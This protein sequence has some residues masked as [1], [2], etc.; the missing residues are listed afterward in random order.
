MP[1]L[2]KPFELEHL[3]LTLAHLSCVT[4][5]HTDEPTT[6]KMREM[7]ELHLI[8]QQVNPKKG[9]QQKPHRAGHEEPRQKQADYKRLWDYMSIEK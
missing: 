3:L 8:G 7:N 9:T 4:L 2:P 1:P 5:L 6:T